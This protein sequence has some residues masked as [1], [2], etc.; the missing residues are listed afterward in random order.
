MT[1]LKT[2][3][4]G[5][6]NFPFNV[7]KFEKENKT[8]IN[9]YKRKSTRNLKIPDFENMTQDWYYSANENILRGRLKL[10]NE[11][12]VLQK[13]EWIKC[14]DSVIYFIEKY[15]QIISIDD[16]VIPFIMYDYQK[17]LIQLY[18]D[19]RFVIATQC[20]QSGKTQTTAAFLLHFA[21]F[22]SSKN[23]A[24]LANKGAQAQEILERIQQSFEFLPKFIQGGIRAYNKRS[25]KL[26]NLSQIFCAATSS[27]SI[28]GKSIACVS[29]NTKVTIRNKDTGKIEKVTMEELE[30]R[31]LCQELGC[32]IVV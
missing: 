5:K 11:Y 14:R 10:E 4:K 15:V 6:E 12:T 16:G 25:M 18:N 29:G 2:K 7:S 9:K 24:I 8:L 32:D 13:L 22:N 21:I 23:I 17:E 30:Y 3:K 19:S 28:R 20:R 26:D 1:I 27:S 31:L